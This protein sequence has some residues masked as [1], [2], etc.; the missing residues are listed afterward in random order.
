M[1]EFYGAGLW[2]G[3]QSSSKFMLKNAIFGST[4]PPSPT[5]LKQLV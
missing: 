4:I 5:T 2:I 1:T 3:K